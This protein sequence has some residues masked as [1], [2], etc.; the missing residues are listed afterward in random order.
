MSSARIDVVLR[1][2]AALAI[3]AA[4]LSVPIALFAGPVTLPHTFTNAS[5]ADAS[6]VNA[7]FT[8]VKSAVD[9]NHARLT[10]VEGLTVPTG[11]IMAFDLATCPTGWLAADGT[12]GRPDLRNRF[13]YGTGSGNALR[14]AGGYSA[15]RSYAA[16]FPGPT[17]CAGQAA[18]GCSWTAMAG[19]GLQMRRASDGALE[20][21]FGGLNDAG[22]V[23]NT[24]GHGYTGT[25]T[26]RAF[27]PP[28][29]SF[30]YCIK[31]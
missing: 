15:V 26:E 31:S 29:V 1:R 5:I 11:A 20:N 9:T 10:T 28:Y 21:S 6:Q 7:N 14:A 8:A 23:V 18:G 3:I 24:Q 4:G 30:L 13:V 16:N 17:A 12:G 2:G 22:T 19:S 25:G 27:L